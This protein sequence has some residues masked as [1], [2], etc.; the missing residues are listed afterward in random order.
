MVCCRNA[1]KIEVDVRLLRCNHA[2]IQT[3]HALARSGRQL[4]RFV[5]P[6][7]VAF[8]HCFEQL[9]STF[10]LKVTEGI[11]DFNQ[12]GHTVSDNLYRFI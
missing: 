6:L 1:L 3:E 8:F 11:L 10:V 4:Q 12:V 9:K 2:C 5:K 7:I